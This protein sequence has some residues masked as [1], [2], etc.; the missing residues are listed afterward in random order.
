MAAEIKVGIG[1]DVKPLEKG[2]T[3]AEKSVKAFDL[4]VDKMTDK[5]AKAFDGLAKDAIKSN[6]AIG[7]SFQ[8]T[9]RVV[10]DFAFGPGAI[11]NNLAGLGDDWKQL[12]KTAQDSNQ[13][14]G[15][16]LLA[17]LTGSGGINLALGGFTLA[18]SLASFGLAAW[19][20]LFPKA[21]DGVDVA[22]QSL[23]DFTKSLSAVNQAQLKGA[24]NAQEELTK[25]KFLFAAYQDG[26]RPLKER[27]EAYKELQALAPKQF[28]NLAFEE[29]ATKKTRDAYD[30]LTAS[31]LANARS[32]AALDLITAKASEKLVNE[33]KITE[34]RR[35]QLDTNNQIA[36]LSAKAQKG[37]I[38]FSAAIEQQ[39]ALYDKRNKAAFEIQTLLKANAKLYLEQVD[40]EKNVTVESLKGADAAG[41]AGKALE[42]VIVK[43]KE[44]GS[45]P[46]LDSAFGEAL[47]KN[48]LAIPQKFKDVILLV[49]GQIASLGVDAPGVP[50]LDLSGFKNAK[51]EFDKN[52]QPFLDNISSFSDQ[53]GMILTEGLKS[54]LEGIGEAIGSALASGTNV[55]SAVGSSLLSTLGG[56]LKQ[57]GKLAIETGIGIKAIKVALKT[58]NPAVAIGAGVALIALGSAVGGAARNIGGGMGSGGSG[59]SE[60][61]FNPSIGSG[62]NPSAPATGG[63]SFQT[64][65]IPSMTIK[66]SDLVVAF[67]R[68]TGLNNRM[69]R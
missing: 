40:L 48:F 65:F 67:N 51:A 45:I 35:E 2:L 31:L 27:Q 3:E 42:G 52:K 59:G 34:L 6:K 53:V 5:S 55:I 28:A 14:I 63:G 57:L 43:V 25:I 10:Q 69:G 13:S 23:E 11:A 54:S 30:S 15:K 17:S 66:G 46:S 8:G 26:N 36:L 1:A 18:L 37:E 38:S 19:T 49:N 32:R 44:L 60:G 41:K 21:A 22:N 58:L 9:S 61:S 39:T 62:F 29:S 20:R 47:T 56:V 64:I 7:V 33:Q 68:E 50:G 4:S 16:T 12:A 24:Q